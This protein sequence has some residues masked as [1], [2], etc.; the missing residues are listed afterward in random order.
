MDFVAKVMP[1][2]HMKLLTN[3]RKTKEQN[4]KKKKKS[5]DEEEESEQKCVQCRASTTS[6]SKWNHTDMFFDDD[7]NE[8]GDMDG[9]TQAS[10]MPKT[11]TNKCEGTTKSRKLRESNKRLPEDLMDA[12]GGGEPL[13]LLDMRK[14]REVLGGP[15]SEQKKNDNDDKVEY[16][17]DGKMIVD[18]SGDKIRDKLK[19]KR[20]WEDHPHA[21]ASEGGR[22]S[23][24]GQDEVSR[25]R[26]QSRRR[27]TSWSA[28]AAGHELL[29]T[30][31]SIDVEGIEAEGPHVTG[32][33]IRPRLAAIR[34]GASR[35]GPRCLECREQEGPNPRTSGSYHGWV[36]A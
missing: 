32:P 11:R 5:S 20:Q 26:S 35:R 30:S 22:S 9:S 28:V 16:T 13:D 17:A 24:R 36:V 12:E 29:E 34:D 33:L 4:E 2:E 27:K 6:K 15:K 21:T 25:S 31:T 23:K 10:S 19:R 18:E 1:Q 14:S 8:Y 7:D 3:I